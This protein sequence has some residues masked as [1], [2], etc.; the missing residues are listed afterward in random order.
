MDG[1]KAYRPSCS[2]S[3]LIGRTPEK[4]SQIPFAAHGL[5]ADLKTTL[6]NF[7]AAGCANGLAKA[8]ERQSVLPSAR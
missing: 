3:R 4:R 8:Q 7:S 6:I 1:G 5:R 2:F